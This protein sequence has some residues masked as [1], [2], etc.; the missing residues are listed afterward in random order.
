MRA[1]PLLLV[2]VG[3]ALWRGWDTVSRR[4]REDVERVRGSC[5]RGGVYVGGVYARLV[6]RWG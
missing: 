3:G 5:E 2:T 6:I 4:A 1:S